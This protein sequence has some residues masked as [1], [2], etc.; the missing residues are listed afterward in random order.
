MTTKG[1]K[2]NRCLLNL[3]D[4]QG[5]KEQDMSKRVQTDRT[6]CQIHR[7]Q[8]KEKKT[9]QI[10][11]KRDPPF[12][13]GGNSITVMSITKK[14]KIKEISAH[15]SS[16]RRASTSATKDYQGHFPSVPTI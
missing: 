12:L 4:T 7:R 15:C 6:S 9:K 13:E 2:M 1:V 8:A 10:R 16:D 14:N 5:G 11:I 3:G